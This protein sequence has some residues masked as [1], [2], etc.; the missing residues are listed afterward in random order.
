M[1]LSTLA[2]SLLQ[3]LGDFFLDL[4]V[5]AAISPSRCLP[6]LRDGKFPKSLS[7]TLDPAAAGDVP[8]AAS[9]VFVGA[10]ARAAAAAAQVTSKLG[11]GKTGSSKKGLMGSPSGKGKGAGS[12]SRSNHRPRR[13]GQDEE[14]EGEEGEG[15]DGQGASVM[16]LLPPR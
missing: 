8:A 16:A 5:S 3:F 2:V 7:A 14:E 15:E 10:A 13:T 6:A 4:A 12:V 1:P 9:S 11:A